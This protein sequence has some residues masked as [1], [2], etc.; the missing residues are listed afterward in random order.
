LPVYREVRGELSEAMVPVMA[1]GTW[2]DLA[3]CDALCGGTASLR[4][5]EEEDLGVWPGGPDRGTP[6]AAKASLESAVAAQD[7]SALLQ[8]VSPDLRADL[9]VTWRREG[10]LFWRMAPELLRSNGPT[11]M[12]VWKEVTEGRWLLTQR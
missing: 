4:F 9:M 3:G 7:L 6:V 5:D 1:L 11:P 12:V 2:G 8:C 10:A